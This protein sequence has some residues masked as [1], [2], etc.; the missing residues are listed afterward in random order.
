MKCKLLRFS[1]Q[2][3][4]NPDESPYFTA[5]LMIVFNDPEAKIGGDIDVEVE[6]RDPKSL[7]FAEVEEMAISKAISLL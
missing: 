1:I 6:H 5:K 7:T 2:A 3:P 4:Y